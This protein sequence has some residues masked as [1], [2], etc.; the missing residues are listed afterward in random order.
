MNEQ[1]RKTPK[2]NA[3]TAL[4]H[5]NNWREWRN[6]E[7][8]EEHAKTLERNERHLRRRIKQLLKHRGHVAAE[9]VLDKLEH[10]MSHGYE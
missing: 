8:L 5:R 10:E 9:A 4:I 2:T 7:L 3:L 1:S 6:V